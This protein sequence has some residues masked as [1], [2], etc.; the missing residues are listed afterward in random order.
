MINWN[1]ETLKIINQSI[2]HGVDPFFI[3][4]IRKVENGD[5]GKEFGVLSPGNETY[6]KQLQVCC[7]TVRNRIYEYL[8]GLYTKHQFS[9]GIRI[10]YTNQF[11]AY[12]QQKWAPI[13]VHNDPNNLN[14]NWYK[15][16]TSI[17]DKFNSQG[18]IG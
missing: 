4:T 5:A 8:L 9:Y 10:C 7:A 13:G 12:F 17:Y 6:D 14:N 18:K 11:I 2:L 15:N 1:T 3:A 16:A